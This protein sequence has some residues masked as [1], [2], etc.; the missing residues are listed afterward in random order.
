[1][2]EWSAKGRI[3]EIDITKGI[4]CL[5]MLAAHFISARLLPFGTFAAPLFLPA[6]G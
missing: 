3:L 4:A 2:K 1:M 6:R 5:L